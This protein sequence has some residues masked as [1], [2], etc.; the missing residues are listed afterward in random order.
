MNLIFFCVIIGGLYCVVL[1]VGVCW[2]EL[3]FWIEWCDVFEFGVDFVCVL[4]IWK[5]CS[6]RW[7][8]MWGF[9]LL[10]SLFRRFVEFWFYLGVIF[11]LEM[12]F[13][14]CWL[15]GD[16]NVCN[17]KCIFVRKYFEWFE[18]W[19]NSYWVVCIFFWV[20]MMFVL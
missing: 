3:G 13:L 16:L 14:L 10:L 1:W 11:F 12:M 5:L 9:L 15:V 17:L 4:D 8:C 20:I 7:W 18:F 6:N 19:F 2:F